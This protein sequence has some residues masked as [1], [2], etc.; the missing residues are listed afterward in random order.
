MLKNHLKL[1]WRGLWKSPLFTVL[2]AAGLAIG[3]AVSLLLY[4]DV[5]HELSFNAYHANAGHIYR[6]VLNTFWDPENPAIL[7]NAPNAVGPAAK[8]D[9]PGVEQSARLLKHEF[10]GSAFV[11]VGENRIVEENLYWADPGLADIFDIPVVA[12]DLA[13]ALSQ[14]NAIALSRTAAAR[15]FGEED[16]IGQIVRIDRM[17]PLEVRAVYEDFPSNSTLDAAVLGAFSSVGWANRALTWSNASFETWLLLN[18]SAQRDDVTRRLSALLNANVPKDGQWYSM[19]LQPLRDVH[20]YSSEMRSNSNRTG[21][22]R[23]VWMLGMLAIAVLLIACFNYMNLA[24]A[25]AQLRFREVG[26]SKTLGASGGQLAQRFYAE[27][28]LMVGISLAAAMGLLWAAIPLFNQLADKQLS[29]RMLYDA[30]TL[31]AVLGIGAMVAAAAGAYPA[32]YLS[33]FAP[34]NLLM[35]SF[36]KDT[37][38]GRI[39]QALVVLQFA[40]SVVLIIG[41]VVLYQQMLFIQQKKLGFE[42]E[43]VVAVTTTAAENK[44]QLQLLEQGLRS[45]SSVRAVGRAQTY[46]GGNPSGRSVRK[47]EED[48]QG[49]EL[50]TN[51][52][53]PGIAEALNIQ[54][55]AGTTLPEKAPGDTTIHVLLNQT[56][57]NY[58][59][60]TPEEAVGKRVHCDLIRPAL[61][62]G[63]MADFH[64]ES[65]HKPIAA[66][67]F[68]DAP[69]EDLRYALVKM[70]TADLPGTMRQ[71]EAAFRTALPH[72]AFEFRFLDEHLHSLYRRESRSASVV[73]VFS[74]LSIFVS[75]LGLF[76]LAAFM[77]EQRA[78]EIGI[79]K[80]LGA[81]VAGITG[82]LAKDFLK[83]VLI[84]IVIASP[85]AYYFMN[86]WLAD[87]AYRIEL[88]WWMFALAGVAAVV[89]AFL[90]VS[91]QSVR[92]ALANPVESLRSE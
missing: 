48:R 51:R 57:I 32:A 76:G 19:W 87:F 39:R 79:R 2:N 43:Q 77:A 35:T 36:R 29:F 21:D 53:S 28:G 24:T 86:K 26:V 25:R 70:N 49:M 22:A 27:A 11:Q 92:A 37:T 82:L 54:L 20:L 33:S 23:Q 44:A 5:R 83:L 88:Q 34:K 85:V 89:I 74:M 72:S 1:A 10:G 50:W 68:H 9:I 46:P 62:V 60:F 84:A 42:P 40:A 16:P 71:I 65:L 55:L 73:L 12:G 58:L 66:Y 31:P 15:Y 3:L 61:V 64:S 18:P 8:A 67:A 17:E 80:V 4:L 38:G 69:T 30:Q 59:G 78:K 52:A 7:A 14:P 91:F 13:K 90:T 81:T 56:A 45:M 47:S 75:C 41:A 63:V 6:V